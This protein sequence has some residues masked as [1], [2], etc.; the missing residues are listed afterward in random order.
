LGIERRLGDGESGLDR[1]NGTRRGLGICGRRGS[2]LRR[3]SGGHGEERELRGLRRSGRLLSGG[4]LLNCGGRLPER[5]GAATFAR[6]ENAF[7]GGADIGFDA[8]VVDFLEGVAGG[9]DERDETELF[10]A[11]GD[12]RKI[13][14]PEIEIE[15]EES[16]AVGVAARLFAN[17]ADDADVGLLVFVGPAEDELLFG[18]KLVAGK[19]AGTVK[20]E[21]NSGS[22][23]GKH[24]A[25]QIGA[26]EEDG[27]FFGDAG[28]AA[29]GEEGAS[30][31][32][33]E[34]EGQ[35]NL[36]PGEKEVDS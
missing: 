8:G 31:R 5:G 28:R 6:T 33:E 11:A 23:L 21:E 19:N 30:E 35:D 12:G 24:A 36:V 29:H 25:V 1:G 16:N 3:R 17:L 18:G 27:D 15:V 7:V 20:A 2:L 4:E 26:D 34:R 10:F 9:T 13:D 22:A 32:P 14:F